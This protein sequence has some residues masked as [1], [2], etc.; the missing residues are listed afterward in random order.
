MRV[1][2]ATVIRKYNLGNYQTIDLRLEAEV[3]RGDDPV[4]VLESLEKKIHDY[5]SGR[6]A[7]LATA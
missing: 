5:Y 1:L 3:E 2:S 4:Q 7:Q 6:T